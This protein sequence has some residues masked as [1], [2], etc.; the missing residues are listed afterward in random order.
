MVNTNIDGSIN[1]PIDAIQGLPEGLWLGRWLGAGHGRKRWPDH[2]GIETCEKPAY[3]PAI[4]GEKI[5][6]RVSCPANDS[7]ARR[8]SQ[9]IGHHRRRI[10]SIKEVCHVLTEI[11]I[12]K[13]IEQVKKQAEGYKQG[14]N[15]GITQFESWSRLTIVGDG[16]VTTRSML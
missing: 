16:G 10:A 14:H 7:L 12:A 6:V 4:G 5:T 2:S 1:L 11:S 15:P 8:P 3:L 9:V 13:P